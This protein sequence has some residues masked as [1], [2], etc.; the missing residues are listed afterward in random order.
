MVPGKLSVMSRIFITGTNCVAITSGKRKGLVIDLD[1][2]KKRRVSLP[3]AD[4]RPKYS[5]QPHPLMRLSRLALPE[6]SD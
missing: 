4:A 5:D 6:G 3:Q 1:Q 2:R